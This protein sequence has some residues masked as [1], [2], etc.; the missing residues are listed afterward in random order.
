M[1]TRFIATTQWQRHQRSIP[2]YPSMLMPADIDRMADKKENKQLT[3]LQKL[4]EEGGMSESPV[5]LERGVSKI[6][7]KYK[8]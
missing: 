1:W 5:S 4:P 3:R 7:R 6:T 8:K 2:D